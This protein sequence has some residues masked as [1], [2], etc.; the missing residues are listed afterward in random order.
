MLKFEFDC[1][2]CQHQAFEKNWERKLSM[3]EL[4]LEKVKEKRFP[5]VQEVTA[6]VKQLRDD[7]NTASWDTRTLFPHVH[8]E[9][10]VRVNL[11]HFEKRPSPLRQELLPEDVLEPP[12][13]IHPSHP[14]YMY[15]WD[16]VASTDPLHPVDVNYARP[17]DD[18]DP[19]WMLNHLS[20]EEFEQS[21]GEVGFDA[22]EVDIAWGGSLKELNTT[23]TTWDEDAGDWTP[24]KRSSH[25]PK[26]DSG[27]S[28]EMQNQH[29]SAN[30]HTEASTEEKQVSAE[31][32]GMVI[33]EFWRVV[34]DKDSCEQ[35]PQHPI[36]ALDDDL[37]V[38]LNSLHISDPLANPDTPPTG[39][40]TP[41]H[42]PPRRLTDGSC[43]SQS[44]PPTLS[45]DPRLLSLSLSS[46]HTKTPAAQPPTNL[47]VL[48][49]H[50]L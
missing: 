13:V 28:R 49:R 38:P 19:S 27:P 29:S 5:G 33:Q 48:Q 16:Y 39:L 18:V 17:L 25:P 41:P 22:S 7:F 11:G 12:E 1:G 43:D 6:L 31:R 9:R 8:K 34:N 40:L 42:T 37:F 30:A 20:I 32:M 14:N 45:T 50:Q 47:Y 26:H 21:S 4:F 35:P 44:P 10:A 3:A 24:E 36:S 23:S 46:I 2:P 15:D